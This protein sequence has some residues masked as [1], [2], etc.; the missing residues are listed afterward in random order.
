MRFFQDPPALGNQYADD[1]VLRSY[2]ARTLPPDVRREVEPALDAMGAL[3]GG[4]LYQQQLADRLDE[5]V[6]TAWDAWGRRVDRI[7]VSRL[8]KVAARLAVEQGL[9]A[10]PY[11]R[12]QGE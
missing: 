11:E 7:E 12:A 4:A 3:A 6:L 2:L 8:W 1:R 9:V 10:I 5:P